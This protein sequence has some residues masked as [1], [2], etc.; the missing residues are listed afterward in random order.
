[1]IDFIMTN[2]PIIVCFVLGI[3]LLIME[4][5][6]PGFGI[7][8]FSGIALEIVALV[9]TWQQHGTMAT[10][11]ML[12]I[13][14]SVLAIAISTSLHSLTKGKLSKSSIVNS[15]TES[16]DAGYRSAE[17]MQVFLGREGTAT[18]ALRP[19]GL[20]EFDG[21]RLNVVSEGDFIENGTK[22]RVTQIE[23]NALAAAHAVLG[24]ERKGMKR[25]T[26]ILLALLML[27]GMALA[28]ETPDAA[29]GDWY[30]L[31]TENEAICLTLR[32]DG[33]FCY[34]SREGTWRKTTDGEYWLTYNI[35]DLPEVM[36][37]MVNSQAAEQ[38]LTAL[39]TETGLD[40]YYGSTAKGVVAHMVRD[41]EELQNVRTPKTDTPLEAFAG[42]WTMET[43]FA[44]AM[45]MTYTLDKGERLAFCTID[46]LTM[47]P[48]AALG[49]FTEGTSYPMTLEDGKLHTTIL[50][51]MT[52]EETLDFDMTFFQT[53]DGSLYATLRLSD[54]PDNPT[55]MFLLIPM[56]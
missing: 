15:H 33:T 23:G 56:E 25:L 2:L 16:T 45:E 4:A 5:L 24:K 22:I 11:G 51:Q 36:E 3:G 14:L 1:M 37:R 49:N 52:E 46:G 32:E 31:N 50:M 18:T 27:V 42:T 40:V 17:D 12:L 41:A 35:H 21:V 54:V 9:L 43:V 13:V 34:D 6:M 26:S 55:T 48:G 20:G 47:L 38:D 30:A 19:T 44:G 39:L 28:E 29:L 8:G 7:A 10:L 53:A